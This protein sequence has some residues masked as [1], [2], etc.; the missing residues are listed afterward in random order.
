ML[1]NF[2]LGTFLNRPVVDES[3]RSILCFS[4]WAS[5]VGRYLVGIY[6]HGQD[7]IC[8]D[9]VTDSSRVIS[10]PSRGS[11]WCLHNIVY[12]SIPSPIISWTQTLRRSCLEPR[13]VRLRCTL[14]RPS[15]VSTLL[16]IPIYCIR[17]NPVPINLMFT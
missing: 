8:Y 7:C 11:A 5:T 14:M 16:V 6:M 4:R 10:P 13:T 9:S 12:K 2:R 15:Q 3:T 1:V 17:K